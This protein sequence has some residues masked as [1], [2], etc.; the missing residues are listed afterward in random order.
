[1]TA[2]NHK[3]DVKYFLLMRVSESNTDLIWKLEIQIGKV[4]YMEIWAH[5]MSSDE[6]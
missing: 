3:T 6:W 1:M 2:A 5:S 4:I